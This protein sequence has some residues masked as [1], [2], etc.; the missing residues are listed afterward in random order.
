MSSFIHRSAFISQP[1]DQSHLTVPVKIHPVGGWHLKGVSDRNSALNEMLKAPLGSHYYYSSMRD[2]RCICLIENSPGERQKDINNLKI[3]MMYHNGE[4]FEIVVEKYISEKYSDHLRP[5][6]DQNHAQE[7][8]KSSE[9]NYCFWAQ[10]DVTVPDGSNRRVADSFRVV[11][12]SNTLLSHL[13]FMTH[14]TYDTFTNYADR[15]PFD[16][17]R[18]ATIE[19]RLA[20]FNSIQNMIV[21]HTYNS[22]EEADAFLLSEKSKAQD[23]N[24]QSIAFYKDDQ[25]QVHLLRY[26]LGSS[27]RVDME[28]PASDFEEVNKWQVSALKDWQ[29]LISNVNNSPSQ[30]GSPALLSAF[31]VESNPMKQKEL[32]AQLNNHLTSWKP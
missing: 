7:F 18:L 25:N 1:V 4:K 23:S 11:F 10:R 8:L 32:K 12:K 6:A 22:L 13:N 17:F 30:V 14:D 5:F 21:K 31:V 16:K 9:S 19:H 28:I 15:T 24:F 20:L 29:N 27:E 3:E 2:P 26:A